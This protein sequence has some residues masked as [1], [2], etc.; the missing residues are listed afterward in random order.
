[1]LASKAIPTSLS[2]LAA[3]KLSPSQVPMANKQIVPY[4]VEDAL[5]LSIIPTREIAP[6]PSQ[7]YFTQ[8]IHRPVI[9]LPPRHLLLRDKSRQPEAPKPI[10]VPKEI[11][12]FH[13]S[14]T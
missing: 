2:S 7:Y 13:P 11:T 5:P 4:R 1:M 9:A 8:T 14:Q 10:K 6:V 3:T 12:S